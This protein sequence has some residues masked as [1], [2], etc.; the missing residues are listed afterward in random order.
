MME[1]EMWDNL[2]IFWFNCTSKENT[3]H[4][5]PLTTHCAYC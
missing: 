4:Y 3:T 1:Q 2:Q 5:N